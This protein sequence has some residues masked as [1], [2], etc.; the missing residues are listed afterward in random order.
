MGFRLTGGAASTV[1]VFEAGLEEEEIA[2]VSSKI[3]DRCS[4]SDCA[5]RECG[6]CE[7]MTPPDDWFSC[8]DQCK[9]CHEEG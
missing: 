3:C 6:I 2:V 7:A 9:E 5:C 1:T 8:C 4:H